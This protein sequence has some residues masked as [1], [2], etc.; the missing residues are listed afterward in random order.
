MHRVACISLACWSGAAAQIAVPVG[1]GAPPASVTGRFRAIYKHVGV[2]A[3]QHAH[4]GG[5]H[6]SDRPGRWHSQSRQDEEV[7]AVL[8]ETGA[9][10][11]NGYFIDLAANDPIFLSNTRALERDHGWRGLCID[12]NTKLL[13]KLAERR[14][15]TVVG[16]V[17]ASPSD[18]VFSFREFSGHDNNHH[19]LSGIV[20]SNP[21]AT[22]KT[23]D[24]VCDY[25]RGR[26]KCWPAAEAARRGVAF[27]DVQ[28]RSVSL[29]DLLLAFH[30]P[31]RI[32]Y[33][34]LDVEGAED[35]VLRE[36]PFSNYTFGAL[37][38]ERPSQLLQK[39]LASHGYQL[40]CRKAELYVH[41]ATIPGGIHAARKRCKQFEPK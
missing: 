7:A 4:S 29:H 37:T 15:C 26:L 16:A 1:H 28:H 12:G 6:H 41:S 30:A 36:F 20:N 8:T 23:N 22:Q 10:L 33:L 19:T 3:V 17:V 14:T 18:T 35:A 40:A 34:S 2:T 11:R 31:A 38:I 9:P 25:H 13:Q 32:N 5:V 27:E 39:L 24:T 21:E